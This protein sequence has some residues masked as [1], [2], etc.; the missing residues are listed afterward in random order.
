M[1]SS[2][3]PGPSPCPTRTAQELD[4][5]LTRRRQLIEMLTAERNRFGA[6]AVVLRAGIREHIRSL[7]RQ[8]TGVDTEISECIRQ[9]QLW[10]AKE[11]L[12][13]RVPG[14]GPVL[15]RTLIAGLPELGR[16]SHKEVA[17]LVGVA[18]LNRDSGTLRGKRL[19]TLNAI[20]RANSPWNPQLAQ[21]S[22]YDLDE[23]DKPV[24]MF[25]SFSRSTAH[26]GFFALLFVRLCV[27]QPRTGQQTLTISV[28][29]S[30]VRYGSH[31]L[32]QLCTRAPKHPELRP[33]VRKS[34]RLRSRYS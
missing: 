2:P 33:N 5:L 16:L 9:S 6:A 17:A 14:V 27:C 28:L 13:R 4:A 31:C 34:A 24:A 23:G 7:E 18:P 15:S 29:L 1:S 8:L 25:S 26:A 19:V 32:R 12:L 20:V 21:D 30:T 10:R 3:P 11:D 22:C